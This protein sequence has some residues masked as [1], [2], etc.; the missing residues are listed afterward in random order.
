LFDLYRRS[1]PSAQFLE[2]LERHTARLAQ[3]VQEYADQACSLMASATRSADEWA[4]SCISALDEW[5]ERLA[6]RVMEATRRHAGSLGAHFAR[7]SEWKEFDAGEI[8]RIGRQSLDEFLGE[9]R[10][11]LR[12]WKEKLILFSRDLAGLAA[13]CRQ[14]VRESADEL[15][16]IRAVD[17]PI[18]DG[19]YGEK[20]YFP[21]S[22]AV[23]A[24]ATDFSDRMPDCPFPAAHRDDVAFVLSGRD[25]ALP[26]A[27]D[28]L[29]RVSQLAGSA[30]KRMAAFL[31]ARE[32]R[33]G[34]W[35]SGIRG[36]L[37]SWLQDAREE[38][39][40]SHTVAMRRIFVPALE[41]LRDETV[42]LD[43]YIKVMDKIRDDAGRLEQSLADALAALEALCAD[44]PLR[45]G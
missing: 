33:T 43:S 42:C 8:P 14:T 38:L 17:G 34:R 35:A 6:A 31:Q 2:L 11:A 37:E 45:G 26:P 32:R 30:E 44:G 23:L 19:G 36:L 13:L 15:D 41:I 25:L 24:Q 12:G 10:D 18:A 29:A 4:A 28:A 7:E 27:R 21:V 5:E 22:A 16:G 9:R 40:G 1:L 39:A 3:A 20:G